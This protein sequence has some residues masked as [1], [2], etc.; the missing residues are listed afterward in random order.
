MTLPA[1][2]NPFDA[3][4][5]EFAER[6]RQG[7]RPALS[8]YVRRYPELADEIR[9]L[10]PAL[11]MM[12]QFKPA[13]VDSAAADPLQRAGLHCPERIGDYRILRE[14]GRGGMGIVYEAEQI[15]LGR[16][17]A[18]K[19]LPAGSLANSTYLER[20]RRE[21][22][23]AA[24]LHHTNIV[25]VFGVGEGDGVHYYAMQFIHGE[26]LDRVLRD[27]QRLREGRS[28][29]PG[30][31]FAV[32][33]QRG[34][35]IA[36]SLLSDQFAPPRHSGAPSA[37]LKNSSPIVAGRNDDLSSSNASLGSLSSSSSEREYCRSVARVGLQVA[38]AL[39]YAHK[40]GILHRDIKPS[41]LLLD[42]QGT[43]W[44]TD[45]GLA[46]ADGAD[47]LTNTGDIVGTVRY[48]APER[49]DGASLPQSDVYALGI[50]LYELLLL[51]PVYDDSNRARLMQRI[52]RE[53]PPRLRR[54][55]GH[56]PRDLETVVMKAIARDPRSRYATAEALAEDLRRFLMDRPILARRN[57]R[58][59]RLRHWCRRNPVVAGLT[60]L[61]ASLL[62]AIAV[63]STITA[64]SL[65]KARKEALDKLW[66]SKVSEAAAVERSRQ[67]GQRFT[68]LQ[69]IREALALTPPV[70][71]GSEEKLQ[72]RNAAVAALCLPDL[73]VVRAWDGFPAGTQA[74]DS[75]AALQRYAR[76]DKD[77]NVTIR[78]VSDDHE[79][80]F[81]PGRGQ[82]ALVHLSPD[83]RHVAVTYGTELGSGVFQVWRIDGSTCRCVREEMALGAHLCRFSPNGTALAYLSGKSLHVFEVNSGQV[84][85]WPLAGTPTWSGIA[86]A[87]D[88][89]R[90]ALTRRV[91][92]REIL[93]V[94][95]CSS[96]TVDFELNLSGPCS[97]IAW[98]P[99]GR[100][101]ATACEDAQCGI[102][103][104]DVQ[105]RRQVALLSGHKNYGIGI[106]F[107]RAG[108]RLF[109]HDWNG[110]MR[111][112]DVDSGRELETLRLNVLLVGSAPVDDAAV[113]LSS[114]GQQ[115]RVLL[116]RFASGKELRTPGRRLVAQKGSYRT[117]EFD[118]SK[119]LVMVACGSAGSEQAHGI[120]L[121]H[122][123]SGAELAACEMPP[124]PVQFGPDGAL[125]TCGLDKEGLLRWPRTI[126]PVSKA[127]RFGPPELLLA[128]P[129]LEVR[130]HTPDGRSLILTQKR[131]PAAA[132]ILRTGAVN[133]LRATGSQFDVR[134]G[135]LSPD[136]RF[137][138]TGSHWYANGTSARVWDRHT[139]KMERS[140][141]VDGSCSV[142]FSPDS[143]W[144]V[145]GAGGT[146]FWR[147]DSWQEMPHPGVEGDGAGWAFSSDSRLLALGGYGR[148]RLVRP[149]TGME[150]ARLAFPDQTLL[151]PL[152][153]S[154]DNGELLAQ[155]ED[156]GAIHVWDLRMIR[157]QLAE[158][159]LDWD[160]PAPPSPVDSGKGV[161]PAVQIVGAD[162]LLDPQRF[163]QYQLARLALM[164]RANPFDAR[165]HFLLGQLLEESQPE[166]ALAHFS[167]ALAFQ[168][169]QPILHAYRALAAFRLRRWHDI[170]TDVTHLLAHDPDLPLARYWL[171]LAHRELGCHAEA[172]ADFSA[173]LVHY[174]RSPEL[175]D[176]R[177]ACYQAL[178]DRDRAEADRKKAR[179]VTPDEARTLNNQAWRLLTGPAAER[180]PSRA[181]KLARQ[182][183]GLAPEQTTY[184]NTLGVAHYRNG[185]L[186]EAV[187]CLERSLAEGRGQTDAFDLYFLAMCY[188]KLGAPEKARDNFDRAAGWCR[189]HGKKLFGSQAAEL[190]AF[191]A[192]AEAC[193]KAHAGAG[194]K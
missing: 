145:T 109:S 39:A 184:W 149:D 36:L 137:A 81:L 76:S 121:L 71:M 159:G 148:I 13:S 96:G 55:D 72:L 51:R 191:R 10:F 34:D 14:I 12:E 147:V 132:M 153:F 35:D 4:A 7:E 42:L 3:L 68:S 116:V 94:R 135:A 84:R 82:P 124:A 77:G 53:D 157:G 9:E 166:T 18:L 167:A 110:T 61:L 22:K 99:E 95:D 119:Q 101:L 117:P 65:S 151:M 57:S 56:I 73:E 60:G 192:E 178:G 181:L 120:A 169:D 70:A 175:Y 32:P 134:Y 52:L 16:H 179:E 118:P 188:C 25:P 105:T 66:R 6:F 136:G 190:A 50:T 171:G 185:E 173:A 165:A 28:A 74:I 126:D 182:A 11:V 19:V 17:V 189:D 183:V 69:L 23:A 98:H 48:M 155:G 172:V 40:Q 187:S 161:L 33:T 47:E 107:N 106:R 158:L 152:C 41:N 130:G 75:D 63:G 2:Q 131:L 193:M 100:L 133:D 177:A 29:E 31:S 93:Q 174:P 58:V 143:R 38:E 146:R 87:P 139:G 108:N 164:L 79:E 140:L 37:A 186:R 180:D 104:W 59:E 90:M 26:G 91:N 15:S 27:L 113:C 88:G 156:S 150:V 127:L 125:W 46:K 162:L 128:G 86:F 114:L 194:N 112:W 30:R 21:A 49:F 103:F 89:R 24:R 142:G 168:P 129:G 78:R 176:L 170:V 62:L 83:G 138:A 80:Y 45:F 43:V 64:F 54:V 1:D 160:D 8:E 92:G 115:R 85:S 111:L 5:E 97:S 67:P 20:F 44:I 144:L 141:P 163:R 123:P 122:W 102:Y 154:P